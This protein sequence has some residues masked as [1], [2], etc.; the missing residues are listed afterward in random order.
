M[1]CQEGA[2]LIKYGFYRFGK[3]KHKAVVFLMA[4]Q[5]PSQQR[6]RLFSLYFQVIDDEVE[7]FNRLILFDVLFPRLFE[8]ITAI[9]SLP[10]D[11]V[12][13]AL[14]AI[15]KQHLLVQVFSRLGKLLL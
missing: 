13:I 14:Q 10:Y 8:I 11:L 7:K 12:E 4:Y 2:Y 6:P 1:L 9:I 15:G 5:A 3:I